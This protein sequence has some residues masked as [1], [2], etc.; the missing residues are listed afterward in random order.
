VSPALLWTLAIALI[1]LGL[2]GIVVPGLPGTVFV[3]AG[4]WLAAAADGFTRVSVATVVVLGVLAA[5][6]YAVEFAAAGFGVK[7]VGAS[8]R[9]MLGAALG[10]MIGLFFGLPGMI[11]GP[12]AGA[13][14]GELSVRSGVGQAARV[15]VAAWIGILLGAVVKVGVA[16]IMLGIFV[17][18]LLVR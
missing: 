3:F 14:I 6:S 1:V 12:F 17:F 8:R 2:I 10:S 11:V 7:R 13:V 15:G 16:F 18:A 5:A 4:M 9:A